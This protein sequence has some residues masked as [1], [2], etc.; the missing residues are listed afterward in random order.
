M[1]IRILVSLFFAFFIWFLYLNFS[2]DN[3]DTIDSEVKKY[4]YYIELHGSNDHCEPFI[5]I[6][7]DYGTYYIH[8]DSLEEF[9]IQDNL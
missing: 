6:R 1:K 7:N 5:E 9:I 3:S 8:P 4:D 2:F